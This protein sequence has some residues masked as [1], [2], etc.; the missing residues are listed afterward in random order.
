MQRVIALGFFD[1]VHIGHAALLRKTTQCAAALGVVAAALTFDV[2]PSRVIGGTL[3]PLLTTPEQRAALMHENFGIEDCIVLPFDEAL[4]NMPHEVFVA[5][6]LQEKY[7]AVGVVAGR[8]YRYGRSG[9]GNVETLAQ[10]CAELGMTCDIVEQVR[11]DGEII[12]ATAIRAL[13][14]KGDVARANE[15]FGRPY[16]LCLP[17]QRGRGL[18][19][20]LGFPTANMILPEDWQQPALGVYRSQV[21]LDGKVFASVTNIGR[22]P[23]VESDSPPSTLAATQFQK[24]AGD[25]VVETH[26]IGFNGDLYEQTLCVALLSFMRPERKFES[27]DALKTQ[28]AMD[29]SYVEGRAN[30]RGCR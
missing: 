10:Q 25:I 16:T 30:A 18:G 3:L 4:M 7:S 12:S 2:P 27:L 22:R 29:R 19:R 6:V 5:Q 14:A 28:M 17:V 9:K 20:Q 23:T 26:L 13:L 11:V 1:G 21:E 24:G 8:D 15:F